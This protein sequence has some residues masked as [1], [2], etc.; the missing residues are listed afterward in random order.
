[1]ASGPSWLLWPGERTRT[2]NGEWTEIPDDEDEMPRDIPRGEMRDW[3]PRRSVALLDAEARVANREARRA[4]AEREARAEA[5][6]DR[7]V[8][9][10]RA[11]LAAVAGREDANRER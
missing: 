6:H 5:A 11:Q 8:A 1:M 2:V 4:Q 9:T 3:L 10:W 7:A